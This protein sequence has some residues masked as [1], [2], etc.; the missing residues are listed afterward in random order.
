LNVG[1]SQAI[2]DVEAGR[3]DYVAFAHNP[4]E[5]ARLSARYGPNSALGRAGK[6]QYFLNPTL[7]L[8]WYALNTS[9][10][11][12]SSAKMRRAVNFAVDRR[13]LLH[14]QRSGYY[15]AIPT[16]QYVPPGMAGFQDVHAYPLGRPDLRRARQL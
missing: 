1:D 9:R 14:V 16:D 13:G 3:S 7:S 4:R 11:L 8:A 2:E 5:S 10:P 6:Q 15:Q 12:F